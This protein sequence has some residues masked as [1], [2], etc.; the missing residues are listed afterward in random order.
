LC[1]AKT[2]TAA[3]ALAV[4]A[5]AQTSAAVDPA[6]QGLSVTQPSSSVWWVQGGQN[7][8]AWT[9]RN[10]QISTFTVVV[11]NSNPQILAAPEAYLANLKNADCSE[12][13]QPNQFTPATGYTIGL[14]NP[15]NQ[16]DY[17]A[18]SET[19]EIKAAGAAYASVTTTD[20]GGTPTASNS[21]GASPTSGGAASGTSPGAA[22]K[23]TKVTSGLLGVAAGLFAFLV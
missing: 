12:L 3:V 19:F 6:G 20:I 11:M 23:A 18:I 2:L 22:T 15:L 21:G 4:T 7:T 13:I 14:A 9:C 17:Y 1:Y 16:S 10:T 8:L 5:Y